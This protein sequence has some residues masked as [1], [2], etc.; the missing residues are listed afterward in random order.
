M[1]DEM[2]STYVKIELSVRNVTKGKQ[3]E[4]DREEDKRWQLFMI[5]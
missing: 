4:E 1:R 5:S 2:A 3:K